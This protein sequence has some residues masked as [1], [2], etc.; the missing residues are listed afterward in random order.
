MHDGID[1]RLAQN[2]GRISRSA[3][4][5]PHPQNPDSSS[6][7]SPATRQFSDES[8]EAKTLQCRSCHLFFP[9]D[10][11]QIFAS[12][13]RQ[14]IALLAATWLVR[15]S[16]FDQTGLESGAQVGLAKMAVIF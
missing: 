5:T 4:I 2:L 1:D 3:S 14:A 7:S 9:F 8:V 10:L 16:H 12:R 13:W 6:F 11:F 15:N